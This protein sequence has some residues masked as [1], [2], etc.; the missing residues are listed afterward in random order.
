MTVSNNSEIAAACAAADAKVVMQER[1]L[2]PGAPIAKVED[3]DGNGVEFLA[4]G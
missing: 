1:E 4:I 2:R 3:P